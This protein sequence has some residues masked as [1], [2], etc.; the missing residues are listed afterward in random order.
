MIEPETIVRKNGQLKA[1]KS[2][3]VRQGVEGM[4]KLTYKLV[5]QNGYLMSE[6]LIRAEVVKPP[7]PAVVMKGTKVILSEGSGNFAWPVAGAQL[8]SSYG[9]RWGRQHKGL[10]MVGGSSI[11]AADNGVVEFVGTKSGFGNCVILN[12]NN[13]YKTVYGHMSKLTAKQG[14]I[15]EK[16]EKLGV[17]GNTGRSTGTHLHFEI[18]KNGSVQN[19]IKYL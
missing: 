8:T 15:V 17:M 10:D 2:K 7:I 13:G 3:V 9:E 16:G 18:H 1:G 14:A 11:L 12:H 4:K 19:P 5:K 6:E